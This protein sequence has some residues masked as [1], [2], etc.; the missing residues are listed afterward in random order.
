M[1]GHWSRTCR[2]PRHIVDLHCQLHG[3]VNDL[4]K[5]KKH[6]ANCV[7]C[8]TLGEHDAKK[9]EDDNLGGSGKDLEDPELDDDLMEEDDLE[10]DTH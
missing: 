9:A 8:H 4:K 7:D 2:T 1:H 5:H 10:G 3:Q 6:E